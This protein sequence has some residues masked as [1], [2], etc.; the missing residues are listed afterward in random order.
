MIY[1]VKKKKCTNTLNL[2]VRVDKVIK[3]RDKTYLH[4]PL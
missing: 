2:S 4:I 1:K 3:Y